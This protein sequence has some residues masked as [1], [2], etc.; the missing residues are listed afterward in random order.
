MS[1]IKTTIQY[2]NNIAWL[3]PD[4]CDFMVGAH[5]DIYR[6]NISSNLMFQ[7]SFLSIMH[8]NEIERSERYLRVV[9][10]N[11]YIVSRGALR[12]ILGN[13]LNQEPA[14][15]QFK[16][17][18]NKKPHLIN[19]GKTTVKYNISHSGDWILLAIANSEIGAD[20]EF[21]AHDF[22]YKDIINDY[23]SKEEVGYI[24][25]DQSI[26]RFYLLWTRKEALT[27]ATG[28]G[29]DDNLQAIPSLAGVHYG[30][31]NLATLQNNW[32]ISSFKLNNNYMASVAY[33]S[34][35]KNIRF[36]DVEFPEN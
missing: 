22:I 14:S 3:S 1:L 36:M 30:E 31:G 24:M 26:E 12:N 28:K 32:M 2:L 34:S 7:K 4:G 15:V 8:S 29:L 18:A 17:G 10:K 9:D 6:I 27:K 19:T 35:V 23:F 5:V 16:I 21:I 11:R 25:Q 20:I 33:N 13:Y